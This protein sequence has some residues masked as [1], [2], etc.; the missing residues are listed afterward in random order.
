MKELTFSKRNAFLILL[1]ILLTGAGILLFRDFFPQ[2]SAMIPTQS[3]EEVAASQAAVEGTQAFFQ[4]QSETGKD[5]WLD[6]FCAMST[7]SGCTFVQ[8]GADRL[9]KKYASSKV[10]V[11]ATVKAVEQVS[12]TAAEQVWKVEIILSEPLPGSNKSKE[13]AYVLVVKTEKGWKFDR[14]LLEP[15][16]Q[17]LIERQ[18]KEDHQ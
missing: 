10:S 8:M 9:W 18:Q 15:E 17:T 1:I 14:F 12:V 11:Q 5:A 4:I 13:E 7:E 6:H 3:P 16:I 2:P